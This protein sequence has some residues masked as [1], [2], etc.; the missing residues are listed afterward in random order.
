MAKNRLVCKA[1][2]KKLIELVVNDKTENLQIS[3]DFLNK[4]TELGY[5][6][7]ITSTKVSATKKDKNSYLTYSCS[8]WDTEEDYNCVVINDKTKCK[9]VESAIRSAIENFIKYLR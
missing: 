9:K 1:S 2:L 8:I 6:Y 7:I 3:F 5:K 4:M